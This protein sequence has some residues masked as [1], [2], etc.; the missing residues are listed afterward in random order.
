MSRQFT[1]PTK[2]KKSRLKQSHI[3]LICILSRSDDLGSWS[4]PYVPLDIVTK[5]LWL[6][7]QLVSF[8]LSGH[9]NIL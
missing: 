6:H 9:K 5:N 8:Y 1:H 3:D 2:K 7:Y 4:G